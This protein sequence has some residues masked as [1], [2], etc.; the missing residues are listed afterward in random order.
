MRVLD[1]IGNERAA[2]AI[3]DAMDPIWYSLSERE[4]R[5]LDE[6]VVGRITSLEKIRIPASDPIFIAPP[7]PPPCHPF[8]REPI[9]GWNVAA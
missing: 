1:E 2:D 9:K 3:R 4:L 7:T 8:P 5:I 6:R